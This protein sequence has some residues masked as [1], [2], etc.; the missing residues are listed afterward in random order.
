MSAFKFTNFPRFPASQLFHN[1]DLIA[2]PKFL[3]AGRMASLQIA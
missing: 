3:K 2:R 1:S